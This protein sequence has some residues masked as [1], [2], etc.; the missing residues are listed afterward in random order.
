MT[1]HLSSQQDH[2]RELALA[3][4]RGADGVRARLR[5]VLED[6]RRIVRMG[7]HQIEVVEV[8]AINRLLDDEA[9]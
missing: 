5:D 4:R 6:G 2:E 9:E 7:E 1:S 3:E 8:S